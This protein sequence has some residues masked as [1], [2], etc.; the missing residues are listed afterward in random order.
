[1]EEFD[2]TLLRVAG[3]H[4]IAVRNAPVWLELAV[5][6]LELRGEVIVPCFT[7]AATAQSLQW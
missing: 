3:R 5:W 7:F 4:G 6:A 2:A 1:M